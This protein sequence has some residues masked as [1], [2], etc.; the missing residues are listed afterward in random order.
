VA[1]LPVGTLMSWS[2][3][4]QAALGPIEGIF[5]F[6]AEGTLAAGASAFGRAWA[7]ARLA[8]A[9]STLAKQSWR[10]ES[11]SAVGWEAGGSFGRRDCKTGS[12][13][14]SLRRWALAWVFSS[15]G[16]DVA[17][18]MALRCARVS[19]STDASVSWSQGRM[20]WSCSLGWGRKVGRGIVGIL[21]MVVNGD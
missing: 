3:N 8:R 18:C 9:L 4:S 1:D 2:A 21:G 14:K 12:W 13:M 20:G 15:S 6:Q 5:Q 17:R 16:E 7:P 11:S 10:A 19:P